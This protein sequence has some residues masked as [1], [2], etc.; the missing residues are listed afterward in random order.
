MWGKR[1]YNWP[2]SRMTASG[3]ACLS[4]QGK[5][6]LS[7]ASRSAV[8]AA[9]R[10]VG[11][12]ASRGRWLGTNNRYQ[13]DP[14]SRYRSDTSGGGLSGRDE[15]HLRE[16]LAASAPTHCLD[17]WG[18][19]G[20]ALSSHLRGDPDVARHLAYYA[21]LR[22]AVALLACEGIGI[23]NARQFALQAN[24]EIVPFAKRDYLD[25][26]G[27]VATSHQGT[28]VATWACLDGWAGSP[29]AGQVV[30][31]VV[32]PEGQPLEVWFRGVAAWAGWQGA[33]ADWPRRLG[34][35][36]RRLAGDRNA[37][38]AASYSPNT[39]RGSSQRIAASD[40]ATFAATLWRSIDSAGSVFAVLDRTLLRQTAVLVY[41]AS[42]GRTADDGDRGFRASVS[43]LVRSQ[44][45]ANPRAERLEDFLLRKNGGASDLFRFAVDRGGV[46]SAKHHLSAMARATLLL[47]I[48]TGSVRSLLADAGLGFAELEFWWRPLIAGRAICEPDPTD[49]FSAAWSDLS[50]PI[51][52]LETWAGAGPDDSYLAL[53]TDLSEALTSLGALEV[54]ALAGIQ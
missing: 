36:L 46:R 24:G 28:H 14:A 35:D 9:L 22:A 39:I 13:W 27:R 17:G 11:N 34:L 48:A 3:P 53:Q 8:V 41:E 33:V 42:T 20:R 50:T 19:L 10:S 21:E 30:G 31:S 54:A 45:F 26:W 40:A 7:T 15:K 2:R 5:Q 1:P 44:G 52:D 25:G 37:R 47:R 49:R 32:A 51:D 16:H 18:M 6:R 12:Y 29:R 4:G 23:L 38:N 43:A